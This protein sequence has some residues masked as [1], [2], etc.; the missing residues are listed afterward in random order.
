MNSQTKAKQ[1]SFVKI[2]HISH[3]SR[4]LCNFQ[5]QTILH[6]P[7]RAVLSLHKGIYW[8][9]VTTEWDTKCTFYLLV[10]K[11]SR[12]TLFRTSNLH[13]L[14]VRPTTANCTVW[15]RFQG[16]LV[17]NAFIPTHYFHVRVTG[18]SFD[19]IYVRA[20][21]SEYRKNYIY[22]KKVVFARTF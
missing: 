10:A 14:F 15:H 8:T 6:F 9:C 3:N 13:N 5:L 12:L 1:K 19:L 17:F 11:C 20:E 18:I 21:S 22:L 16:V 7:C 4:K 2:I